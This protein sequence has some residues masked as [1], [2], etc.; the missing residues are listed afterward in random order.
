MLG[1]FCFWFQRGWRFAWHLGD[2]YELWVEWNRQKRLASYASL[3]S[4][5]EIRIEDQLNCKTKSCIYLLESKKDPTRRQY[6]GQTGATIGTR[7]GQHGYDIDTGA[8]QT[9]SGWR[10]A[11]KRISGWRRWWEWRPTTRGFGSI[12][13]DCSSTSTTWWKTESTMCSKLFCVE[14]PSVHVARAAIPAKYNHCEKHTL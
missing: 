7:A 9:T 10:E 5:S 6:G 3:T 12:S 13:R 2:Y 8:D 11:Q 4:S 14:F 1:L